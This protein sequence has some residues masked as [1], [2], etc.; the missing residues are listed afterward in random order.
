MSSVYGLL[1]A[2]EAIHKLPTYMAIEYA[3]IVL[4][5]FIIG[6][7]KGFRKV[8]WGGFYWLLA[9]VGFIFAYKYLG[10]KNLIA[11]MFTGKLEGVASFAWT[12][13][14]AIASVLV[15]LI[16]YGIFGAIFRPR[17][18]LA[19]DD[20]VDVDEYGFEYEEEWENDDLRDQEEIVVVKGG[21]KPK[22]FG[23]LAGGFM[24]VVNAGA[25]LAVITAIFL[26]VINATALKQ[27]YMGAI[28]EVRI[29]NVL[30]NYV[31]A[32]ALDCITIGIIMVI[33]YKGYKTGFVGSARAVLATF[34]VIAVVVI[35]FA[36]PFTKFAE[37]HFIK[38]LVGRCTSLYAKVR[39]EFRG[40]LGKLTAGGIMA[41]AGAV[42]VLLINF[43]LKKAAENVENA[44]AI[45]VIDGILATVLYLI[46]GAAV[47]AVFWAVMYVLTY[48]GVIGVTGAFNENASLSKE[49]FHLA[50]TYLKGFADKFL[51]KFRGH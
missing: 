11:K 31:L 41:V 12:F 36:L 28:F 46:I 10:N 16:L 26:L 35:A 44:N 17:E 40:I 32:Y 18:V 1:V 3:G 20:E 21:G 15:S 8:A 38:S 14:L 7:A 9:C 45:R 23:R 34:G 4:I 22:F 6:F 27:G 33:A 13:T 25:I 50:E 30:L 48:S 2:R 19:K 37:F 5:A 49:F 42:V 29:S 47:V 43:L 39:P 51:L 24:A